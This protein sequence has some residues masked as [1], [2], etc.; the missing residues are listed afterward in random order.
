MLRLSGHGHSVGRLW[1]WWRFWL[2]PP[3]ATFYNRSAIDASTA[4]TI[5]TGAGFKLDNA[6]KRSR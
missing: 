1:R 2:E 6:T 4:S 3:L 5:R